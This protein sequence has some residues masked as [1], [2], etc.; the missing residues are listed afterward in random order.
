MSAGDAKRFI[1]RNVGPRGLGQI[2]RGIGA[3][4]FGGDPNTYAT[5]SNGDDDYEDNHEDD[6]DDNYDVVISA[7]NPN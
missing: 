2:S 5:I 1:A 4:I 7:D 3:Q 6:D